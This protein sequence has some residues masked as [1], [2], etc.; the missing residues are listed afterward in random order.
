MHLWR[1]GDRSAGICERCRKK[2]STRFE[3]RGFPIER[4]AMTVE[5]VL[6]AVCEECGEIV[7]VPH[8]STPKIAEARA[9]EQEKLEVRVPFELQDMLGLVA[10]KYEVRFEDLQAPL[11]RYYLRQVVK[12]AKLAEV[13]RLLAQDR[14]IQGPNKG[15]ISCLVPKPV[16]KEAWERAKQAGIREKS[17]LVR[18]VILCAA[19]DA[20]INRGIKGVRPS[21]HRRE[22]IEAIA[23]SV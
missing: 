19:M 15:R 6:V 21:S 9:R 22:Q 20:G 3:R 8:Q 13:A 12:S 16:W 1:E 14:L 10:A 23:E 2:V 5:N 4:P 18:G 7:G 11:I 17:E